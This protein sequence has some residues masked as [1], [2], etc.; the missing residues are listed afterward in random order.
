[1]ITSI[2]HPAIHDN[3]LEGIKGFIRE[4][5]LQPGDRLPGEEVLAIQLGVGRP[6]LRE[7]LRALEAVG[8]IETRKGVGRFVGSF[9]AAAYVRNFTTESLINSFSEHDLAETRCLL[10]IA[11]IPMAVTR[12]T[13]DDLQELQELLATMKSKIELRKRYLDEDLGMH[14]LIMRHTENTLI[15]VM[16]DAVY[17]LSAARM[18]NDAELFI[19]FDS[20]KS[21]TDLREHVALTEALLARDSHLAQQRLMEHFETT[22]ERQGFTPLW[23]TL[24]LQ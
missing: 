7:A 8:A 6:A 16:L 5:H 23:H 15:A 18:K 22:A 13:D 10:E 2:S 3:I 12:L 14:R 17:A 1:M 9:A 21:A 20:G 4:N 24:R 11:S 19:H